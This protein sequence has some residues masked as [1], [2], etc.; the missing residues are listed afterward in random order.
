MGRG[1]GW[2]SSKLYNEHFRI[3]VERQL[4]CIQFCLEIKLSLF[5][6]YVPHQ[7][8]RYKDKIN[9][10]GTHKITKT[11]EETEGLSKSV[12]YFTNG[13]FIW[14]FALGVH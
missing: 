4:K 9:L 7:M 14:Q 1:S 2:K 11:Y 13:Y 10:K 12:G 5:G 6:M 8:N 3:N